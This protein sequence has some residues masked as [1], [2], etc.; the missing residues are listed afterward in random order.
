MIAE[1]LNFTANFYKV[2]IQSM[3]EAVILSDEQGN[4]LFM[5]DQFC[6]LTGYQLTEIIGRNGYELLLPKKQKDEVQAKLND[7]KKGRA[8]TYELE[9]QKKDGA[10]FFVQNSAAP[11]YEDGKFIGVMSLL[12]D[13]SHE[14]KQ[15][16][17]LEIIN[18]SINVKIGDDYFSE[19]TDFLC[20]NLN[21]HAAIVGIHNLQDNVIET[22][23]FKLA[24]KTVDNVK[25]ELDHTPC[26]K[27]INGEMCIF[28]NNVQELFP[29]DLELKKIGAVSYIGIPLFD[30][31]NQSLGIIII[32]DNKP[33]TQ[34]EEKKIILPLLA[35]RTTNELQ[36]LKIQ[37]KLKASEAD[38]KK[39]VDD[40]TELI[41]LWLPD[42]DIKF[43]NS[44]YCN[45]HNS[46]LAEIQKLNVFDFLPE[47]EGL[48]LKKNLERLKPKDP[49][50]KHIHQSKN[51]I[52]GNYW[53]EWTD[54]AFFDE[55]NRLLY[56]QSIGR[57]IT[58]EKLAEKKLAENELKF[59]TLVENSYDLYL[60]C[61]ES[62]RINY[63]SPNVKNILGY[64]AAEV[65][66]KKVWEFFPEKYLHE[67][68]EEY[69]LIFARHG[70][71]QVFT[72]MIL[73]AN[74]EEKI[75]RTTGKVLNDRKGMK[76]VIFNS[77]DITISKYAERELAKREELL[78][79]SHKL[80]KTGYLTWDLKSDKHFWSKELYEMFE[81]ADINTKPT[82]DL[83]INLIHPADRLS[84]ETVISSL[85]LNPRSFSWDFKIVTTNGTERCLRETCE[86]NRNENGEELFIGVIQDITEIKDFENVLIKREKQIRKSNK[87]NTQIIET[88]NKFFYVCN[89]NVEKQEAEQ[90][91]Y[92]SPQVVDFFGVS[93]SELIADPSIWKNA[94]HPE[95]RICREKA[96]NEIFKSK[97]PSTI[98]YRIKNSNAVDYFWVEEYVRP[99]LGPQDEIVELYGSLQNINERKI[100]EVESKLRE[101]LLREAQHIAKLG[102]WEWNEKTRNIAF[103][104]EMF[105]ILEIDKEGFGGTIEE[106]KNHL[107]AESVKKLLDAITNGLNKKKSVDIEISTTKG[108]HKKLI[109]RT[110]EE[111]KMYNAERFVHGTVL[112]IS[113]IWESHQKIFETEEKFKKIFESI[114][115]IYYQTNLDD[116]C[117]MMS[118][119][120]FEFLGYKE[121]ELVGKK[122][123][124]HY[125]FPKVREEIVERVFNEGFI[126][127]AEVSLFT[128][129]GVRI[130]VSSNISILYDA[131]GKPI[132]LQGL[133][134]N[135]SEL[136]KNEIEREKLL[137]E[138]TNK[139]NQLMQFNY[140]V[141]H[142]LRSPITNLL[143]LSS[144]LNA[145][146][147]LEEQK[148]IISHIHKSVSS[149]DELVKDLNLILASRSAINENKEHV[150]ISAIIQSIKNNLKVQIDESAAMI[151]TD[152]ADDN[153]SIYTIKSYL[154]SIIYNLVNNAIK[155]RSDS[156]IPIIKVSCSKNMANTIIEISD[157]G[158]GI[159]LAKYEN[160]LFGLYKRF[161]LSK[162][163]RGLGLHMTK[164]QVQALDGEIFVKSDLGK[165]TTFTI[166]IPN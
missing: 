146:I 54:T 28:Q 123:N 93:F 116:V 134:R 74:K 85:K 84:V 107:S 161:D 10:S 143:G 87:L 17:L 165:G 49:T 156:R 61:D 142:N 94:I 114:T 89:V 15:E 4:I 113:D 47:K 145:D 163:G 45:F 71:K 73:S 41:V 23:S 32:M 90:I 46:T 95:D 82:H 118:P 103:N 19:L 35:D 141:S 101:K 110:S 166:S 117:T 109:A 136:K 53:H 152:I 149:M 12:T 56:Y 126:N 96:A 79:F 132:G 16:R 2:L 140:I 63:C 164:S 72:H 69:K 34:L 43:A 160:Q 18:T 51:Q 40:Q 92:A 27:V 9:M 106:L 131:N 8:E 14:K 52:K 150:I 108:T 157:N 75:F 153:D 67:V 115:D 128:R 133:V 36:R 20:E 30:S 22:I 124:F 121:S 97:Q 64:E 144:L 3:N 158:A 100:A 129:E 159:D 151:I 112:D 76:T 11:V 37:K 68:A 62:G 81:I 50:V 78:S 31:D 155:Y 148:Q 102:T 127:N 55:Q 119:S 104:D 80:S 25:Y 57:D 58:I 29:K 65:M 26:S 91:A 138:L 162:E 60:I 59:R 105:R 122:L 70:K 24:G 48:I 5:N 135:V 99:F 154:Q 6:K 147:H 98:T 88:S 111:I 7:R 83:L 21:V 13:I 77:N 86:F 44:S 125:E 139:Y 38:Y 39:A 120:C 130:Y 33:M 66:D 42:G 1:G 137:K